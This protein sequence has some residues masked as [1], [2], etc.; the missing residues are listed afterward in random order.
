MLAH[1]LNALLISPF[2]QRIVGCE[3]TGKKQ[4]SRFEIVEREA[5]LEIWIYLI[6]SVSVEG[7]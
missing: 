1:M 2:I 4:F 5:G 3:K 7:T 6:G